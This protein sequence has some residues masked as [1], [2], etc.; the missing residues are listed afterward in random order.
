MEFSSHPNLNFT[1]TGFSDASTTDFKTLPAC[2]KSFIKADPSPFFTIFGAGQPIFISIILIFLFS[3]I[4]FL[5]TSDII[6]GSFPN[7]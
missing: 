6:Y 1:D 5:T 7:I 3:F 2:S 4:Y